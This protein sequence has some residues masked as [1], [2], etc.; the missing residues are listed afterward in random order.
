MKTNRFDLPADLDA[1]E[2]NRLMRFT[3]GVLTLQHQIKRADDFA[4]DGQWL[5]ALEFLDVSTRTLNIL[6]RVARE[7]PPQEAQP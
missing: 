4:Q 3:D 2:H 1:P 5:M 7:V 6:K